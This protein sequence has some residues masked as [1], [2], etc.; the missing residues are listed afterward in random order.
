MGIRSCA[1]APLVHEKSPT[2]RSLRV[3][4][5]GRAALPNTGTPWAVSSSAT[6][7]KSGGNAP[8]NCWTNA[9]PGNEEERPT[10][11]ATRCGGTSIMYTRGQAVF[12][13]G[14]AVFMHV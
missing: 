6:S 8:S 12:S 9:R 2:T 1:S 14:Q 11:S 7:L 13:R 10:G 5:R 4:P 3:S